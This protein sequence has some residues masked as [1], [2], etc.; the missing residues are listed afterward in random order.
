MD[1]LLATAG[2]LPQ[3]DADD[4]P[5]V[6]ALRARGL[7]ID[8]AVWDDPAVEWGA[9]GIVVVRSTW[10]YTG[11]RDEF[12]AWAE[13]VASL[14]RLE[15][16]ADVLRWNTH[17]SYLIELEERGAPVVPT[18]WLGQGDRIDLGEL[19]ADRGWKRA[20]VKP[21]VD[22]GSRGLRRVE[23]DDLASGQAHLDELL[24]RADVMVQPYL[25]AIETEGERSLV[26]L[27]DGFS[28]AVRKRPA[29]GDFRIQQRWGGRYEVEDVSTELRD[30]GAWILEAS[31]HDYLYARVDLVDDA[32]G[33]P[34][35]AEL[36]VAEPSLY[37]THVPEAA[38]RLAGLV[39]E[40]LS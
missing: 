25:E 30:L 38:T 20:V 35:L 32:D 18:A 11:R 16:P 37:L 4:A 24:A 34:Q 27:G 36:E 19:L 40:R 39:E 26:F 33:T 21:A 3:L 15:N 17:K 6:D 14:T 23:P 29:P 5:L 7:D 13:R 10:D 8:V 9:A 31:G 1:V 12:L 2:H 22:S 28:H